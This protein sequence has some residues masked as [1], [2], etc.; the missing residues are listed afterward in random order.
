MSI[1]RSISEKFDK[2]MMAITFAEANMHDTT[3]QMLSKKKVVKKQKHV[4]PV[5]E[6]NNQPRLYV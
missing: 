5:K 2:M 3:L 4:R 6:E 1:L